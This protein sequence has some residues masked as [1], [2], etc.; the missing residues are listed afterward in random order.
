MARLKTRSRQ[1]LAA[2]LH[3][4]EMG[5]ADFWELSPVR[6]SDSPE[7]DWRRLL[8]LFHSDDIVWIGGKYDSCGDDEPEAK[9]THCRKFFRPV[10]EWLKEPQAPNQL[11]C[12]STFK[13][14]THSRCNTAVL[15]RRFFVIESDILDKDQMSAVINW[16]RTFMR[17]RAIVDT[18]GKSLH[19]W[20]EPPKPELIE[21]LRVLLPNLGRVDGA[22]P[23]LDPALFKL[24][25]PCRLPG[26]LRGGKYQSLLYLDPAA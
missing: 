15:V 14:G 23:T 20:F 2:I 6:L 11:T 1:S 26:A 24:A 12:P 17:L 7:D 9:K 18:A 3:K 19:G 8:G 13:P 22:E 5:P 25:Q 4:F 10:E 21:E 16:C